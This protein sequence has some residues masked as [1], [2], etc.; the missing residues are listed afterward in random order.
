M[1]DRYDEFSQRDAEPV[2]ILPEDRDAAQSWQ[3]RYELPYPL[4]AD[5]DTSVSDDYDQ[6]VRF[7][8]L[9]KWS[10]FLGRMP[11][12]VL[13]DTRG[14]PEVVWS[15]RGSSTFDRPAIDDILAR[16]DEQR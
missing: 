6:P 16:I 9:G 8:L 1:R 4:C 3:D 2:S 15:H 13:V 11:V 7:G 12:A 5:P 10:D 14:D